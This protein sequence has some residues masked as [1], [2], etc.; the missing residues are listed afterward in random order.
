MDKFEQLRQEIQELKQQ[1]TCAHQRLLV[2]LAAQRD[3]TREVGGM[4]R[5]VADQM[6]QVAAKVDGLTEEQSKAEARLR[7]SEDRWSRL[8]GALEQM[9]LELRR[10][11]ATKDE[12]AAVIRRLEAL[13][14]QPPAA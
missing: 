5:L 10:Q 9:L 14:Q 7:N 6:I 8:F 12:L 4:L 1:Q 3:G 2:G 13:E 11:V